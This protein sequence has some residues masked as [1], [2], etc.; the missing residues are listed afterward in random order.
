VTR[1]VLAA[2]VLAS[3]CHPK[4]EP[5]AGAR[6]APIAAAEQQRGADACKVFVARTCACA[7]AHPERA[8]VV[9]KCAHI[10]SLPEAMDMALQVDREPSAQPEDVFRA[11]GEVRQ[12]IATCVEGVNWLATSRCP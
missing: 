2:I 12:V 3:A 9:D 7:K 4:D 10:T 6:P 8:D 11:Q 5:P 1:W